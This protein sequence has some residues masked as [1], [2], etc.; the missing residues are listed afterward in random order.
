MPLLE[1]ELFE[2]EVWPASIEAT[3]DEA[4]PL[5]DEETAMRP[6][7]GGGGMRLIVDDDDASRLGDRG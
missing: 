3:G 2:G 6:G 7:G 5:L 1:G 4:G